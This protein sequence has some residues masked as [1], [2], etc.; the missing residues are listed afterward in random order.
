MQHSSD[1]RFLLAHI[2]RTVGIAIVIIITGTV[3]F[4]AFSLHYFGLWYT[5]FYG[6]HFHFYIFFHLVWCARSFGKKT[7][8]EEHELDY[9]LIVHIVMYA[10]VS[11]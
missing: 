6:A 10:C 1:A 11:K 9:Y 4:M 8:H 7:Y 5:I 2:L 3:T